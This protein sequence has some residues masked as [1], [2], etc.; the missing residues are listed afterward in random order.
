MSVT[1]LFRRLLPALAVVVLVG[2]AGACS[3]VDRFALPPDSE[4]RPDAFLHARGAEALEAG[5][6]LTAREYFRRLVDTY[7]TS[8][9]RQDAR[10]GIG[11]SYLG[12][13][14][15]ESDILAAGEF[16]EFLRFYPLADRAD[17]AQYRLALSQVRQVLSP[18][19][20]Q[21]ATREALRELEVFVANY[22][23]SQYLPEVIKLQRE[24]RDRLSESEFLIGRHYYRTRWYPGAVS[25][26]ESLLET[27]PQYTRRDGAYFFLAE[28]YSKLDRTAD[29]RAFYQKVLDE[30]AVS[31]YLE[32]ARERLAAL[33]EP[34]EAERA[35]QPA[36]P[37]SGTT[38]AV[39]V[40][41]PQ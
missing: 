22:P 11:D 41:T 28:A 40:R 2:A 10:L 27:D 15:I 38:S 18:Q 33:G 39:D 6:W 25:R 17:Y 14:R 32:D 37:E 8:E 26:L 36:A 16:R 5:H 34:T 24:T 35:A 4:Q 29:A 7:P 21:T 13:R 19:R 30:F 31:E 3:S 9:Y 12:E 23:T 1:A 20:D